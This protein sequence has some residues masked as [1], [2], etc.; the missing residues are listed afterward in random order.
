MALFIRR[1]RGEEALVNI[2]KGCSVARIDYFCVQLKKTRSPKGYAGY[3]FF[4]NY[5][6][7]G[8]FRQTL[9]HCSPVPFQDVH[10]F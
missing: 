2:W 10:G 5:L 3:R 8:E 1:C 6:C 7:D 9:R 4:K